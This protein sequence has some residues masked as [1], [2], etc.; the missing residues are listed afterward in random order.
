[1]AALGQTLAIP[2]TKN[3]VEA[4]S[5]LT[6]KQRYID[7]FF[8]APSE[9]V[10]RAYRRRRPGEVDLRVE[11]YTVDTII[12]TIQ[13]HVKK[14]SAF[15][16]KILDWIKDQSTEWNREKYDL[17]KNQF[18]TRVQAALEAPAMA[19][20]KQMEGIRAFQAVAAHVM[21][22]CSDLAAIHAAEG[23]WEDFVQQI[24]ATEEAK[25]WLRA[26]CVGLTPLQI[27][28]KKKEIMDACPPALIGEH[29]AAFKASLINRQ[30][31]NLNG[32]EA[33]CIIDAKV[34][35]IMDLYA[36]RD[37]EGDVDPELSMQPPAEETLLRLV[38]REVGLDVISDHLELARN[39]EFLA[40]MIPI[41]TDE[42]ITPEQRGEDGDVVPATTRISGLTP[43]I[44]EWLLVHNKILLPQVEEGV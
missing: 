3:V 16:E 24:F 2:G 43:E 40:K 34:K 20:P 4:L 11:A 38:K 18:R 44:M 23:D 1:M 39:N 29:L 17:L 28:A 21:E 22:T 25:Q 41:F 12:D 37:G 33:N 36:V 15:R 32:I 5:P 9:G 30:P 13:E 42:I 27:H 7:L 6:E 35:S 8:G 26:R 19:D 31:F 10:Q 14:S